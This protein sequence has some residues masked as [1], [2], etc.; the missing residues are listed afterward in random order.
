MADALVSEDTT[1]GACE[2]AQRVMK[3][4]KTKTSSGCIKPAGRAT[5]PTSAIFWHAE[6][7]QSASMDGWKVVD[8]DEDADNVGG[9]D[10]DVTTLLLEG[11]NATSTETLVQS[12]S[13]DEDLLR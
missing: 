11:R 7:P 5:R 3:R 2:G 1:R 13:V 12:A 4:P 8:S 10:S 9:H 6:G